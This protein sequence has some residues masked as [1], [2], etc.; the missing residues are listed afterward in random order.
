MPMFIPPLLDALPTCIII[1]N[2]D[3]RLIYINR[4]A[5]QI[6]AD[7]IYGALGK[8]SASFIDDASLFSFKLKIMI[9]T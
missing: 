4:Q 8:P 5:K 2:E 3:C 1:L 9:R 6:L 7:D